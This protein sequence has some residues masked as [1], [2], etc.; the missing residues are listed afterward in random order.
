LRLRSPPIIRIK[1]ED[2]LIGVENIQDSAERVLVQAGYAD[3][4]KA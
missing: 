1:I 2:G 4:A 3:V